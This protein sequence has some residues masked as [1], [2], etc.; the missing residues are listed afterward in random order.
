[1]R[2]FVLHKEVMH[3]RVMSHIRI[4]HAAHTKKLSQTRCF[5]SCERVMS[6]IW[7]RCVAHTNASCL[8]FLCRTHECVMSLACREDLSHIRMWQAAHENNFRHHHAGVNEHYICTS[9][10]WSDTWTLTESTQTCGSNHTSDVWSDAWT[11]HEHTWTRDS[12]RVNKLCLTH[13]FDRSPV[14]T[15]DATS[16]IW[17]SHVACTNRTSFVSRCNGCEQI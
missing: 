2:H 3:K 15:D 7:L 12:T 14:R 13:E 16:N 9:D 8:R 10:V 1:M 4:S 11:T 5:V 17:R 6:H